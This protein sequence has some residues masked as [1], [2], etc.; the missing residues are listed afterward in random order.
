[1]ALQGLRHPYRCPMQATVSNSYLSTSLYILSQNMQC[2]VTIKCWF[3]LGC[4][5]FVLGC[6]SIIC[7]FLA[8]PSLPGSLHIFQSSPSIPGLGI[9]ILCMESLW[10]II[11]V[12]FSM[13]FHKKACSGLLCVGNQYEN[14]TREHYDVIVQSFLS[15]FIFYGSLVLQGV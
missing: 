2:D 3:V 14:I 15:S 1:M 8:T 13:P 9:V 4:S 5:W 10:S 7:T 6:M 12:C 11:E